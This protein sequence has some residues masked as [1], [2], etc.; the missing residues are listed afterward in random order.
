MKVSSV[1]LTNRTRSKAEHLQNLYNS[2][3][4]EENGQNKIKVVDWGDIPAFDMVINAT[5]VGLN[6]GDN[7]DLDFSKAG[8]NKFFYD[9]I[10][11]PKETN[12][13]KTGNDLGS[14]TVNGKKMFIFQAASAFKIWHNIQPEIDEE[15][16]KL[17][18]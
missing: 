3:V 17:L 11:N 14:K 18:D 2:I 9:V 1:I 10:Y 8:K 12:F 6:K 4:V 16:I 7:L 5:S 15:V 13:L